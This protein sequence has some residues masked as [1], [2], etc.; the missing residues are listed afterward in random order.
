MGERV[1]TVLYDLIGGFA[2]GIP[3][4]QLK[5][6]LDVCHAF[7]VSV[8][9]SF[10]KPNAWYR[11]NNWSFVNNPL[12]RGN[13]F[14]PIHDMEFSEPWSNVPE[15]MCAQLCKRGVRAL[16]TYKAIIVRRVAY[17]KRWGLRGWNDAF[18]RSLKF[19]EPCH[20]RER[21]PIALVEGVCAELLEASVLP[22]TI[23]YSASL[24]H[25]SRPSRAAL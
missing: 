16:K 5:E 24:Q 1:P 7:Q 10:L 23:V 2:W 19:L 4:K 25:V 22:L 3:Y 14:L 18:Q 12:R 17:M 20:F 13:A 8:P 11:C 9:P 21:A 6:Q 15:K